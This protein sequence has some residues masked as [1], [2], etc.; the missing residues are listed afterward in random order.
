MKPKRETEQ[1]HHSL[2]LIIIMEH[3]TSTYILNIK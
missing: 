1:I 2:K 3:K